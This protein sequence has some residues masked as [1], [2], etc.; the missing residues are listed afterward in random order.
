[1]NPTS[2]PHNLTTPTIPP[3]TMS[4]IMRITLFKLPDPSVVQEA[5]EKYSA[6][7][8][9]ALK[10]L[11]SLCVSVSIPS[12]SLSFSLCPP[13]PVKHRHRPSPVDNKSTSTAS[14]R[15]PASQPA[16]LPA[17]P[18]PLRRDRAYKVP[19]RQAISSRPGPAQR[20]AVGYCVWCGRA[21]LCGLRWV[22]RRRGGERFGLS[23]VP[24]LPT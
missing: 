3:A 5:I 14:I 2:Q 24:T 21:D 1:L 16:S 12:L 6:L 7:G 17:Y 11:L 15:P 13:H 8:Q 20:C 4:R 9:A 22:V 23:W 19:A 10:V 18:P